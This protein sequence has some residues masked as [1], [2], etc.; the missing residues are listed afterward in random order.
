M[1]K[2]SAARVTRRSIEELDEAAGK[3]AATAYDV[4]SFATL[5]AIYSLL[6]GVRADSPGS[7]DFKIV[8]NALKDAI[9]E[10]RESAPDLSGRLQSQQALTFRSL[11]ILVRR[12]LAEQW[13]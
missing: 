3:V 8:E 6:D 12:K 1:S 4:R 10:A 9:T 13:N 11:S 2:Q 7:R 5:G